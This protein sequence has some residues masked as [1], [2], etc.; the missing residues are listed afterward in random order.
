MLRKGRLVVT[1]Q[2][3]KPK[4]NI[5]KITTLLSLLGQGVR[6]GWSWKRKGR[7]VTIKKGWGITVKYKGRV[8]GYNC[9]A[10]KYDY[11]E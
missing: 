8:K 11:K 1:G 5:V 2:I 4:S 6:R 7:S 10:Q 3:I 9:Q